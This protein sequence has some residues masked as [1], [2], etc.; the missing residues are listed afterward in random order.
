MAFKV[1]LSHSTKVRDFVT[2]LA[3][4]L[5]KADIVPWLCQVDIDYRDNH[6][7]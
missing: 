6:H 7:F 5:E 1:F 2:K 3:S 4:E